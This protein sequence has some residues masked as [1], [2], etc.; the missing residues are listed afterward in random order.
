MA[1]PQMEVKFLSIYVEENQGW[2]SATYFNALFCVD[3]LT[4]KV[5][6]IGYFPKEKAINSYRNVVP[7]NQ[8]LF[9][10]PYYGSTI[11][12]YDRKVKKIITIVIPLDILDKLGSPRFAFA[13]VYNDYLYMYGENS[14]L[15]VKYNITLKKFTIANLIGRD[16]VKGFSASYYLLV[17]GKIYT[18]IN[19]FNSI[20]EISPENFEFKVLKIANQGRKF[21]SFIE[22]DGILWIADTTGKIFEYN[23]AKKSYHSYN[24]KDR[25]K[26]EENNSELFWN[27]YECGGKIYMTALLNHSSYIFE[28]AS[29]SFQEN[30]NLQ[31]E[32]HR[33]FPFWTNDIMAI[34]FLPLKYNDMLYFQWEAD[35][36]LRILDLQHNRLRILPILIEKKYYGKV[37]MKQRLERDGLIIE[38]EDDYT[39]DWYVEELQNNFF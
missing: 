16:E 7:Y 28:I 11:G 26:K 29:K 37:L 36:T 21:C 39:L 6:Y 10:I 27:M 25:N 12:I 13:Y 3:F 20:I 18:L 38:T 33:K 2:F 23:L 17:N 9:F 35:L 19:D 5:K 1:N 34:W 32:P 4:G 15:I 30:K 8:Y 14:E 22:K 24:L 31:I